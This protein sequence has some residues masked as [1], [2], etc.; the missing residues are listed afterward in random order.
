MLIDKNLRHVALCHRTSQGHYDRSQDF[1]SC[2]CA[3]LRLVVKIAITQTQR[4]VDV[5]K[6]RKIER[7]CRKISMTCHKN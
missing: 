4:R 5:A 2:H 1:A 7:T 6:C 3:I